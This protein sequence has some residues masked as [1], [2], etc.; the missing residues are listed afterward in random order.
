MLATL[1]GELHRM[2]NVKKFSPHLYLLVPL[3]SHVADGVQRV[4]TVR[5]THLSSPTCLERILEYHCD[6]NLLSKPECIMN[7]NPTL[8]QIKGHCRKIQKLIFSMSL[9]GIHYQNHPE[10]YIQC[11]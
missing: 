7:L 9:K 10:L 2:S 1:C 6:A 5:P 8:W 3:G 4:G 11:D